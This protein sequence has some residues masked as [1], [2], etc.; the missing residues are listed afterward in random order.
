MRPKYDA[1][2]ALE[3]LRT[4]AQLP[5]A[6]FRE[7]QEEAIRHVVESRGRLLVVQ[8]TGWGK[9]FVYFIATKLL[10]EAGRGPALLVSPL[11]SL[12][13]N[14]I[15]AAERMGVRAVRMTSDN[16]ADWP[17]VE[18]R[19]R[20]DEIDILLIT[21]EGL[22]NERFQ[23]LVPTHPV[24]LLVIDEVHCISDWGHDF[25][26]HYRRIRTFA[27]TFLP[28]V[29]LLAT[30]ATANARVT[31]D[32]R[33][34]LGPNVKVSRGDLNRPSLTLQTIHLSSRTE[35]LAWL[36]EQLPHLPGS[37]IVYT[38]TVRDAEGVARWLRS[39]GI[40]ANAYTA[41]SKQREA[42]EGGLLGNRVKALVATTALG[43]G[44]DK[45][46]L[47]FVIHYQMPGSAV[48]YYQQVG[49][50]GR[51]R[52]A[53]AY[54][55][56]LSGEG[57]SDITTHFIEKAFPTK[58]EVENVLQALGRSSDWFEKFELM[59]EI[60]LPWR[61]IKKVLDLL[62][63]ESPAT[64]EKDGCKWRRT[65]ACLS[66]AFW[67]RT[68]RLTDSRR[69]EQE[70][71][72]EYL[73]LNSD[74]MDFLVRALDGELD[75]VQGRKL[76]LRPT[77]VDPILVK[78]ADAFLKHQEHPIKPRETWPA[79]ATP[80][81]WKNN[82]IAAEYRA[83]QGRALSLW[84][85]GGYGDWVKQDKYYDK[86]FRDDLV[87]A[88]VAMCSRWDP[89]P[90]PKWVTCIPSQQRSEALGEFAKR[91]AAALKLPF[92]TVFRRKNDRPEQKTMANSAHKARNVIGAF[93]VF[94][95]PM[96]TSVL[97]IDDVVDSRWTLTVAAELL[98]KRGSGPVW[99]LA[100][101]MHSPAA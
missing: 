86:H 48:A 10:R 95:E 56:L 24:S 8:K 84:L 51:A 91:L 75:S 88:C 85:D 14:Q 29:R 34:I 28:N 79:G 20:Q 98:R 15:A 49:R 43:M 77:S 101:A 53:A 92:E 100:L 76:P 62:F 26:P 37:G 89:K 81:H 35:R 58:D 54:G 94:K 93:E 7:G 23:A 32:V 60:N 66:P 72:N 59:A 6:N 11:L 45:P 63:L 97:L 13:R 73:A 42:L 74:H 68:Q 47:G 50:A 57:D 16:K 55:I 36:A 4:G 27:R 17:A 44:F 12:M 64:L 18:R 87:Q 40:E 25:R 41:R 5:A 9:S 65:A 38:L 3:L 21:P 19:V 83:E 2:R 1:R 70:Q 99:P 78:R 61:R 82:E 31:D 96:P 80:E 67:E 46:D 69:Q 71:M 30:T 39:H 33:D 90:T 22:Y 52:D